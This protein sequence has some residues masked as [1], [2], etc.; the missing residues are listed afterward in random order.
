MMENFRSIG[1]LEVLRKVWTK[2][3]TSRILP[4]LENHSVL[5]P[6]QFAFLSG[7]GTASELIQLIN[8]LE[9]GALSTYR[10]TFPY[11][12]RQNM[13]PTLASVDPITD[14]P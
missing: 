6:N 12:M 14:N 11:G 2:I 1:L 10:L 4:L 3:V 5:Q 8:V 9:E 13:D 7:R